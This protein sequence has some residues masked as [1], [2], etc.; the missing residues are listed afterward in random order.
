MIRILEQEW[1]KADPSI[2]FIPWLAQEV[3]R[4]RKREADLLAT[5]N[6]E[7]ECKREAE[8]LVRQLTLE[9][10]LLLQH[11]LSVASPIDRVI[12]LLEMILRESLPAGSDFGNRTIV[13]LAETALAATRQMKEE[14]ARHLG[15]VR[16]ADQR[17]QRTVGTEAPGGAVVPPGQ[18][19][20]RPSVEG[21]QPGIPSAGKE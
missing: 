6:H 1:L 11:L 20:V 10:F 8:T 16:N 17:A 21:S 2:G 13:D 9:R 5:N 12:K 18:P 15:P 19:E 14:A 4:L 7:L 3:A